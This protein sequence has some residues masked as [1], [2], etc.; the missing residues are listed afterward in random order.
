M[1]EA[2]TPGSS[3]KRSSQ[4]SGSRGGG[5]G[6][7][8]GESKEQDRAYYG[9]GGGSGS[10]ELPREVLRQTQAEQGW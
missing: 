8:A 3:L 4:M 1:R 7:D 5:F 2:A 9:Q 10:Q 6:E